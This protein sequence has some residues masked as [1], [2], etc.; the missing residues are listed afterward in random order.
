MT[1]R[2][3]FSTALSGLG[4]V[5]SS[6]QPDCR[7]PGFEVGHDHEESVSAKR[8]PRGRFPSEAGG[9]VV[10]RRAAPRS[11][12]RAPALGGKPFRP[13]RSP[14]GRKG[15][16]ERRRSRWSAGAN[17]WGEL[18]SNTLNAGSGGK[19]FRQRRGNPGATGRSR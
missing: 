3:R 1:E 11:G 8:I 19:S 10:R 2:G 18:P 15:F 6:F 17:P 12:N 5:A 14:R 13:R 7:K 4:Q 9:D 16:P